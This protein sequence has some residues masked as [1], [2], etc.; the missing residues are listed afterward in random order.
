MYNLTTSLLWKVCSSIVWSK[1]L[2][3]CGSDCGI[4]VERRTCERCSACCRSVAG[5][6]VRADGY[7]LQRAW[8]Q[9][10]R[11]NP[12][13]RHDLQWVDQSHVLYKRCNSSDCEIFSYLWPKVFTCNETEM[14]RLAW[15]NCTFCSLLSVNGNNETILL[16]EFVLYWA[17]HTGIGNVDKT[18]SL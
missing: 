12:C 4:T 16:T 1:M 9:Q 7:G 14:L 13:H 17:Q 11:H 10:L 2:C 3:N 18:T 8:Q 15:Q 5:S 6:G